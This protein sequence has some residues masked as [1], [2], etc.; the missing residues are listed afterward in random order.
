MS[1]NS[2][3]DQ[4]D[5]TAPLPGPCFVYSTNV[6]GFFGRAGFSKE[7]IC[8]THG[9][10]LKWQC[11]GIP[12][13]KHPF[14][15]FD[16]PCTNDVWEVPDDF[17][18]EVDIPNM[19]A[20][21]GP[22]KKASSQPCW[23]SNHPSC[24]HC[25]QL[26]RPNVY[27][28]GDQCYIENKV[29]EA[30][31]ANWGH[32]VENILKSKNQLSVVMLEIGVGKRLPKLRVRFERMLNSLKITNNAVIVRINPEITKGDMGQGVIPI[33]SGALDALKKIDHYL[34]K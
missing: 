22:P 7:E 21:A 12:K 25:G 11:S 32:A 10:Y 29:E 31:C 33:A 24:P 28:F 27:K 6:D 34:K 23:S 4:S 14:K 16:K 9:T 20:P 15:L 17:E 26:A 2:L 13:V 19:S 1:Q 5:K 30:N 8:N 18:F 3:R